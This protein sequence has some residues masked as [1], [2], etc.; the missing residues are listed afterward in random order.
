MLACALLLSAAASGAAPAVDAPAAF[1]R[2]KSLAGDWQGSAGEASMAGPMNVRY[3]VGA[4]GTIVKETLFHGTGHEMLNVY[5]LVGK[6]LVVTHYC[7][8]GNQPQ[9]TLREVRGDELVFDFTGGTNLD[10]AK[11]DHAH[12]ARIAIKGTDQIEE[13]WTF[14]AG[15]KSSGSARMLLSRRQP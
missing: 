11:D 12:S 2:L 1:A 15:G 10:P 9:M 13:E 7:T 5:H 6:D 14:F 8:K 3:E 4:G